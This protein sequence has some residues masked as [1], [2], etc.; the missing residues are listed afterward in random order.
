MKSLGIAEASAVL[1]ENLSAI[2]VQLAY[3]MAGFSDKKFIELL[4]NT[5]D[6]TTSKCLV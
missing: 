4:E 2:S 6:S 5:V 1:K 3:K